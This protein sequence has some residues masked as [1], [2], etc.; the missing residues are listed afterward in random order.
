VRNAFA[1]A[2]FATVALLPIANDASAA[3]VVTRTRVTRHGVTRTHVVVHEGFPI[4]RAFPEV[5]I[6]PVPVVRVAPRVYLAPVVFTAAVVATVP[7]S[8]QN[9]RGTETLEREDGW[10]DFTM[11]VDRRGGKMLLE[12]GPGA[13]QISFAEVV[14]EN[15]ETQVVDFN[16]HVHARG[17]Y[18]LLNFRDGRKVDHVRVVAK[19]DTANT[20]VTLHLIG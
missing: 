11:N 20:D 12:I 13:A 7:R 4:R 8:P 19:A 10:T 9:W 16:D 14:F 3:R 5:V 17:T 2:L 1:I 18:D 15:G 6:R